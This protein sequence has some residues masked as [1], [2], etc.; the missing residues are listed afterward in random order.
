MRQKFLKRSW[1]CSIPRIG[2]HESRNT[3]HSSSRHMNASF[4]QSHLHSLPLELAALTYR[5]NIHWQPKYRRQLLKPWQR[6]TS[7]FHPAV[8]KYTT[9][10][11]NVKM[12]AITS[13]HA[14]TGCMIREISLTQRRPSPCHV[15]VASACSHD[16]V[17][18]GA[19]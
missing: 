14:V 19:V 3:S 15:P 1:L 5:G 17:G 11:S 6:T 12:K 2:C 4:S 9:K 18:K 8:T 10:A 13:L 7:T 16:H